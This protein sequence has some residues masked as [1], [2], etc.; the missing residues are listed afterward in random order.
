M[1]DSH[2]V[3]APVR[4][5][6]TA[7]A[8]PQPMRRGSLSKRYVKCSKPGCRCADDPQARHGPYYSLTR[9]SGGRTH[10][11]LVSAQQAELVRRQVEAGRRF[12]PQ[13]D[14]YWEA[15]EEWADTELQQAGTAPRSEAEK[16]GSPR[17]SQPRSVRR[18]KRS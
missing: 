11:R 8:Q 14:A 9:A 4:E 13:V 12:R 3:P 18:S 15:C 2:R 16:R 6:A 10:S 1:S 17:G 7:L 5:L